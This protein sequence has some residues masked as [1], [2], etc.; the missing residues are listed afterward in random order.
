MCAAAAVHFRIARLVFGAYDAKGGGVDHGPRIFDSPTC[1]HRPD[2][3]GGVQEV[4][5]A[6]LLRQFFRARR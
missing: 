5:S 4:Q 3:V 2:I 6:A 1:L